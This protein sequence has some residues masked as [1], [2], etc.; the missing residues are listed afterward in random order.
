MDGPWAICGDFYICRFPSEKRDCNRNTLAMKE[1]SD[2]IEDMELID[3]QLTGA[4]YTW[5]KGDNHTTASRIDRIL[6]S[7]EWNNLF[8]NLKQTTFQ[9]VTSDH[10]PIAFLCGQREWP[11]SYFK[12]ENGWLYAEGFVDKV[13]EWWSDFEF[14]RKSNYVLACKFKALKGKLKDWSRMEQGNL[15]LK[16]NS[17]LNQ[18]AEIESLLNNRALTEK[19]TARKATLFME[20]EGCLK[21][22]EVAWRHWTFWETISEPNRIKEEVIFFYKK[23]SIE[24]EDWRPPENINNLPTITEAE[25]EA[26]QTVFEEQ[27][28]FECLKLC[29]IDKAPGPDGFTMGFYIK[30]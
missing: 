7:T 19:E 24:L 22:E 30:C 8:S 23:L 21:N 6:I 26:L 27:E 20:Y 29:A 13:K 1:F 2:F 5:F 28:V 12:F 10:V 25:K 15:K 11:K 4:S 18:M 3:L 14:H 16:K 17:I 9:R